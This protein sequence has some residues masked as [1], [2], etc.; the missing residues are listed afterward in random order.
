MPRSS[1]IAARAREVHGRLQLPCNHPPPVTHRA[2]EQ[3]RSRQSPRGAWTASAPVYH[4]PPVTHRAKGKPRSAPRPRAVYGRL[5]LPCNHAPP[6]THRAKEQPRSRQ[7]PR[8]A[9]TAQAR[10]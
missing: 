6:A 10:V 5:Q 2:K 3:P 9:R 7:G 1:R 4:A 8:G